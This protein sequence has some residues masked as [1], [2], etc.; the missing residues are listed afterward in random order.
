MRIPTPRLL[1]GL[2]LLQRSSDRLQIGLRRPAATLPVTA[3][4]ARAFDADGQLVL[5]A[6]ADLM[7]LLDEHGVL[8]P[9]EAAPVLR[10]PTGDPMARREARDRAASVV[11]HGRGAADARRGR[12]RRVRVLLHGPAAADVADEVDALLR[13]AGGSGL[14]RVAEHDGDPD[15]DPDGPVLVVADGE[16]PRAISD[17]LVRSETPHLYLRLVEST[18]LLGPWVEPAVTACLRCDDLHHAA[19]DPAWPLLVQQASVR[20]AQ[21]RADGV[22]TPAESLAVS[23]AAAGAARDLVR[24]LE[25]L[26]PDSWGR[27]TRWGQAGRFDAALES[28]AEHGDIGTDHASEHASRQ[29]ARH[30]ACGCVDWSLLT[31]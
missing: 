27:E 30:A 29:I 4:A 8:L 13:G 2:V 23:A 26:R 3:A 21:P 18:V 16:P 5:A 20:T 17:D 24:H 10:P 1:P 25:G 22:T 12:H 28:P 9:H 19:V 11:R 6:A 7:T 31:A 14:E 15:G